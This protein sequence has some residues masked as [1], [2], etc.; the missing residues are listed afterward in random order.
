MVDGAALTEQEFARR[1]QGLAQAAAR[2]VGHDLDAVAVL[3]AQ[4]LAC[5]RRPEDVALRA[6]LDRRLGPRPTADRP[7]GDADAPRG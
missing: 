3:L 7:A 6:A 4:R 2:V 1:L 5:S